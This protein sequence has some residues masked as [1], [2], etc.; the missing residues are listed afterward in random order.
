VVGKAL[1]QYHIVEKL[2]DPERKRRLVHVSKAPS[3][4]NHPN[5]VHIYDIAEAGG[6]QYI[7]M[8]CAARRSGTLIA[9]L[10]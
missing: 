5:I 4:L 1:E 8:E 2:G 10:T 7:A 3:A 9:E 6:V